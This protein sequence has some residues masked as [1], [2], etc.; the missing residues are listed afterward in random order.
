MLPI[1][2]HLR[3]LTFSTLSYSSNH[4]VSGNPLPEVWAWNEKG[5]EFGM[6]RTLF[7]MIATYVGLFI[8]VVIGLTISQLISTTRCAFARYTSGSLVDMPS[9]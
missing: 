6:L 5:S 2:L 8:T 3:N 9:A 7:L 1:N 4:Q